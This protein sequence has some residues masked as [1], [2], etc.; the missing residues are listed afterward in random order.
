MSQAY[1][2]ADESQTVTFKAPESLVSRFDAATSESSHGNRSDALRAAMRSF[3]DED[4]DDATQSVSAGAYLPDD[5]RKRELYQACLEFSSEKFVVV[6]NRHYTLIAQNCQVSK[7]A[8]DANLGVLERLGYARRLPQ[9]LHVKNA[10]SRWRIKPP[11]A[12]PD[13][14]TYRKTPD[15]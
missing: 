8:V 9:P 15:R 12:D 5:E 3:I 2:E 10:V 6:E 13:Q 1:G 14:W 11:Q 7:E 4:G